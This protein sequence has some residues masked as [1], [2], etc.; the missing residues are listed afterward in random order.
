MCE[1]ARAEPWPLMQRASR[2]AVR[3]IG[4]PQGIWV[5]AKAYPMKSC[6]EYPNQ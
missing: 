3:E 1:A 5:M 4:N 6:H 2:A